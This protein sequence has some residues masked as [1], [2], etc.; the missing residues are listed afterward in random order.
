MKSKKQAIKPERL[1]KHDQKLIN[2]RFTWLEREDKEQ[3]ARKFNV[4]ISYVNM[5][6][7]GTRYRK[8]IFSHA[9]GKALKKKQAHNKSILELKEA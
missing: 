4:T 3:I 1:S 6:I 9:L 5:I 7:A 8:D 2:E